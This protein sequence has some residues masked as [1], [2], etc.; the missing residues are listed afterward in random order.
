LPITS[1][2]RAKNADRSGTTAYNRGVQV[3][4]KNLAAAVLFFEHD[5]AKMGRSLQTGTVT[6]KCQHLFT[7]VY[8]FQF[9]P[10]IEMVPCIY[11]FVNVYRCYGCLRPVYIF[12]KHL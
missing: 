11:R 12:C 8:D 1:E 4:F 2:K 9:W 5:F 6:G 3:W 10:Y 7:T